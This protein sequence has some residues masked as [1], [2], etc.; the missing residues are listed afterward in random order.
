M[1]KKDFINN[2]CFFLAQMAMVLIWLFT[3]G[4]VTVVIYIGRD[5]AAVIQGW[6]V[7][8]V[9]LNFDVEAPL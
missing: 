1:M 6:G 4:T 2:V 5:V 3:F 7:G 8:T 9:E